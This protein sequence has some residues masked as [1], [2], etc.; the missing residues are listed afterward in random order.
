MWLAPG[1]EFRKTAGIDGARI[2]IGIEQRFTPERHRPDA[3]A[4]ETSHKTVSPVPRPLQ[5]TQSGLEEQ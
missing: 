5:G 3:H 2:C 1:T 4:W